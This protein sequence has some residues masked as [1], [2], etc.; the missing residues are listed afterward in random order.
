M[1]EMEFACRHTTTMAAAMTWQGEFLDF[2]EESNVDG[3]LSTP[4]SPLNLYPLH[5]FPMFQTTRLAIDRFLWHLSTE[6]ICPL[7]IR[8]KRTKPRNTDT[9][10][11]FSVWCAAVSAVLRF[12]RSETAVN[13]KSLKIEYEIVLFFKEH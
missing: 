13:K 10:R 7:K 3:Y 4:N 11:V 1:V 6:I 9:E 5:S 12:V 8:R 2:H